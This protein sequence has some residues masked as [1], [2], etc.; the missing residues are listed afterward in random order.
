M[1]AATLKFT[2]NATLQ[3]KSPSGEVREVPIT[4]TG[5]LPN[6]EIN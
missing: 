4:G 1:E 2:F 6:Q 3:I 5:E